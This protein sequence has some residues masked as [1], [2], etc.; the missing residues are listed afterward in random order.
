[1]PISFDG[2]PADFRPPF[3]LVEF[4]NSQAIRGLAG[5]PYR[6]LL[7]GQR[8]S[9]G[10][11]A[12]GALVPVLSE[13]QARTFFGAGSQLHHM[14]KAARAQSQVIDIW[15]IPLD[16][17]GGGTQAAADI[18]FTG[19]ATA[20]GSIYLHIAG[21]RY[22]VTV[23]V[24]ATGT[25]IAAALVAAIAADTD[26]PFTAAVN[27]GDDTQADLTAK[28]DGTVGNSFQIVQN[29]FDGEVTPAGISVAVVAF[30]S[31]AGDP[32]VSTALTPLGD[33]WFQVISTPYT[34]SA[35]LTALEAELTDRWG[36]LRPIEGH[37]F[38]AKVD[39]HANLLSYGAA[40]NSPHVTTLSMPTSMPTPTYEVAAA[41][42][43]IVTLHGHID[44]AR[45]FQT[46]P[47]VGVLAPPVTARFTLA[48]RNLQLKDGLATFYVQNDG[49]V[50]IERLITMYQQNALGAEDPSYRDVNTMLTL[51]RLR[52][53]VRNR[54]AL[55]YPR[56][57]LASDGTRF[58]PGQ[59]VATPKVVKGELITLFEDWEAAG[60]VEGIDQFKADLIVERN[61][62]DVNRL[63]ILLP[64]DIVNQLRQT[65]TQVEFRL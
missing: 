37:A 25:T 63:D 23:A 11:I 20:A 5:M 34:D 27:G 38:H 43:G 9:A 53:D 17:A 49:T 65:A 44:P 18:T 58:G 21:R 29:Y 8:T 24:G 19:T 26:A 6:M 3:H 61:A 56:H 2:I 36:P 32:S 64:P 59:V 35:N 28:N 7:I 48:E 30:A 55:K 50:R 45:P 60:L 57:K 54:L 39:S 31:G 13:A 33:E 52:F 47:L 62:D 4:D 22:A 10:T 14:V 12:E 16:D 42:A 40:R 41:L 46:L 15:A 1:M 51:G